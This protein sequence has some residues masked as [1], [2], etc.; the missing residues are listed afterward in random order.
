MPW[1][2]KGLRTGREMVCWAVGDFSSCSQ[3]MQPAKEC[4]E[5]EKR[6]R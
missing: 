6:G 2:K 1:G 5:G 3:L 4:A